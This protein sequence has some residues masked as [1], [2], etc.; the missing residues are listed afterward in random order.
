MRYE[1]RMRAFADL[2]SHPL[3]NR[4]DTQNNDG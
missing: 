3:G 4:F 1:Q 2:L